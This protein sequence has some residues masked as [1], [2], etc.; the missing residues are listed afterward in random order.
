MSVLGFPHSPPFVSS[1]PPALQRGAERAA[2]LDGPES[3]RA[4]LLAAARTNV[5]AACELLAAAIDDLLV[6][7]EAHGCSDL[8][9]WKMAEL[10]QASDICRTVDADLAAALEGGV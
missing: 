6:C 2:G 7:E 4:D 5:T 10:D 8:T 1:R 9:H 3:S